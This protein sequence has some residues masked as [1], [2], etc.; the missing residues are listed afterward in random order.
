MP[1][2]W[3]EHLV[4]SA[5]VGLSGLLPER[6]ALWSA[7][8]LGAFAGGV[9]RLRRRDVE[10]HLRTAFPEAAGT[11][12]SAVARASYRHLAREALAT[13]RMAGKGPNHVI[14]RT[15]V[16]GLDTL[17][18]ALAAGKGA[19]VITGHLGNWEVGGAALA[20]RG[21]PVDAVALPRRNPLVERRVE[22]A[23]ERLGLKVIAKADAGEA[24]LAS[25]RSGRVA[26]LLADQNAPNRPV[27]V[28]FLGRVAA[29]AR[30]PAVFAL[31]TGAPV[32]LGVALRDPGWPPRYSV[33]L[34]QVPVEPTGDLDADVR[35]VTGAHVALFE[36]RVRE[37][38]A[39]YLW[40]HRRWKTRPDGE[41]G[42]L[43]QEPATEATV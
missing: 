19:L 7:E 42:P 8:L 5:V 31:R 26:A 20:A 17:Q 27:F 22:R 30:G 34:H 13:L 36:N 40:Q 4:L 28:D 3:I 35:R 23:R 6:M 2:Q 37:A 25:L 38:P 41:D 12:R 1:V 33:T 43:G 32:F 16:A 24:V 10:A 15:R 9:L 29:T 21:V 11:W 39:Q 18:M 14:E